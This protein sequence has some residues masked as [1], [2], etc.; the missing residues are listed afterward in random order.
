M[1]TLWSWEACGGGGPTPD[2]A[3]STLVCNSSNSLHVFTCQIHP[4]CKTLLNPAQPNIFSLRHFFS[5]WSSN[6]EYSSSPILHT[7]EA[8]GY[9]HPYSII[10]L[11][12]TTYHT[13]GDVWSDD[14]SNVDRDDKTTPYQLKITVSARQKCHNSTGIWITWKQNAIIS[15][16][17]VICLFRILRWWWWSAPLSCAIL[18]NL[19]NLRSE[20][21]KTDP[22]VDRREDCISPGIVGIITAGETGVV[23]RSLGVWE[24]FL[25]VTWSGVTPTS[26]EHCHGLSY[27]II[28]RSLPQE[29]IYIAGKHSP[30]WLGD[31]VTDV[32]KNYYKHAEFK[33]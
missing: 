33:V 12:L 25:P 13:L 22:M 6:I 29:I 8:W 31:W 14:C 21:I 16:I 2:L 18:E 26:W 17:G 32:D 9:L 15:D 28:R 30:D 7:M 20:G 1:S 3:G 10:T 4:G 11:L 23:L 19:R 24:E 27:Q 5:S